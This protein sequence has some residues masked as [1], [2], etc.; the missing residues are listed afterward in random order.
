VEIVH[1]LSLNMDRA[2]QAALVD[3]GLEL[4]PGYLGVSPLRLVAF[5]VV[6]SDPKWPR[7]HEWINRRR[8]SDIVQ[9]RF[10]SEEIGEAQHLSIRADKQIGYPQP[11][12][13]D[14][15]YLE[16]TYD[17]SDYC[18]A[19][20]VGKLQK[21]PF[22]MKREPK[23]GRRGILQLNWVFD[24]FFAQ[25]G[26]P[27]SVFQASG[28]EVR[29]VTDRSRTE[30]NTVVQLSGTETV[31]L[32]TRNLDAQSCPKCG[33]VK[34]LPV[35]R[36]MIPALL[37]RPTASMVKSVEW[38]GSGASAWRETIITQEVRAALDRSGIQGLAFIPVAAP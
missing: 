15:G 19:C 23:W 9:T 26:E 1:R 17:L 37:D 34:Y 25:V 14:F 20:G 30:L 8:P 7:W 24:E 12:E 13:A 31:D 6:E 11:H 27:A 4:P 10:S 22:Q 36:G 3:L 38:F 2:D 5:D 29:P 18:E 21:A 35:V 16:A 33:R 28:V 32:E